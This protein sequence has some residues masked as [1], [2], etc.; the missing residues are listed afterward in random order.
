MLTRGGNFIFENS[1]D[2]ILTSLCNRDISS[3]LHSFYIKISIDK[4]YILFDQSLPIFSR[5]RK[6]RYTPWVKFP[7]FPDISWQQ[8][9]VYRK[10]RS[11]FIHLFYVFLIMCTQEIIPNITWKLRRNQLH[12]CTLIDRH[13]EIFFRQ[14]CGILCG[15]CGVWKLTSRVVVFLPSLNI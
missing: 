14:L 13:W 9:L 6:A 3:Q 15:T 12:D 10:A 2:V 8:N 7:T 1:R 5:L 11:I 4:I